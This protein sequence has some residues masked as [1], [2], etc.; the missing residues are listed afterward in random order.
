MNI[1]LASGILVKKGC[2][3]SVNQFYY[4]ILDPIN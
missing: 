2:N 4:S 1:S 3:D